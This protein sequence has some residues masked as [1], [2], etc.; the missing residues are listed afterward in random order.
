MPVRNKRPVMQALPRRP[1][2]RPKTA[3]VEALE[4]RLVLV[5]REAFV[6]N[7]Y[8]VTSINEIAKAAR[9]SKNTLY[10]RFPS[11]ADLFRKIVAD[12]IASVNEKSAAA[13]VRDSATLASMLRAYADAALSISLS[14]DILQINRLIISECYQFPE[15]AEAAR[16]RLQFGVD[17]IARII[18]A[19]AERDQIRCRNSAEAAA[20][21]LSCLQGWYISM[22]MANRSVTAKER[23][24]WV[25][26]AVEVFIEGRSAW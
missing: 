24:T 22:L 10:A 13:P 6:R 26:H 14:P 16:A 20:L 25:D 11:K 17:H 1:R 3:D 5:A 21:F 23:E 2:G 4:D 18:D 15:L 8:G 12:Q 19:Y 7:G 9:I